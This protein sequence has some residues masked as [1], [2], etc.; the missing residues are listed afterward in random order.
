MPDNDAGVPAVPQVGPAD[1]QARVQAG[2]VLLDVREPAEWTAGHAPD[3]DHIPMGNVPAAVSRLPRDA[4]I[5][6]VCR[7]GARSQ[8]VAE[9][10][11]HQ[12]FTVMNLAGGMQ[13]WAASGLRVVADDGAPGAVV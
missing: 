3:A 1:A 4:E 7:S 10:L 11:A 13:A 9:W 12:G 6:V 2:A 8:K 5:V